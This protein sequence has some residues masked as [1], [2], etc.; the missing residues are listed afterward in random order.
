MPHAQ[1]LDSIRVDWPAPAHVPKDRLV[2]LSWALGYVP[3]D[4]LDPYA[5]CEWLNG[6]DIPRLLFSPPPP[7]RRPC[8]GRCG[9]R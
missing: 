7:G 6:S 9:A 5:P 1:T 4:L 8:A 2:D 3:N